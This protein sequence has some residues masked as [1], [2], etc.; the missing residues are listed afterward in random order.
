[1]STHLVLFSVL[2]TFILPTNVTLHKYTDFVYLCKVTFVGHIGMFVDR[3][4]SFC[5]FSFLAIVLSVLRFMDSDY[6]FSIFKLFLH[7]MYIFYIS[8]IILI[9]QNME[10]WFANFVFYLFRSSL[11]LLSN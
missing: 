7:Q 3:C 1:M 8:C 2:H 11:V 6:P 5:T 4:M 9:L 10:T